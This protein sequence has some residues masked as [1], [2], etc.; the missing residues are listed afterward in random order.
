MSYPLPEQ[1]RALIVYVYLLGCGQ[2]VT[3]STGY[4]KTI[5]SPNY[6]SNYENNLDCTWLITVDNSLRFG[7]YIVKVT[8]SDFQLSSS[9]L[10]CF[11]VLKFYDG[12][13]VV[14]RLLG[15]YCGSTHPEVIYSTGEN[16]YVK[17]RTGF[18]TTYKGFKFQFTAVK[19]GIVS[20]S[21]DLFICAV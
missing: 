8:F 18:L 17:F 3:A 2:T 10:L 15:S 12:M 14:S 1:L 11:D 20:L 4:N 6:P 19:E 9:R 16:L 5:T 13:N 21:N 7:G